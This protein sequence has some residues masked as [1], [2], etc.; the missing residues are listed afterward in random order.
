MNRVPTS[1]TKKTYIRRS[2]TVSTV[3]KSQASVLAA[4]ARTKARQRSSARRGARPKR[5]RFRMRRIVA[6]LT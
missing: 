1:T 5:A 3:K 6:P 2:V 4:W